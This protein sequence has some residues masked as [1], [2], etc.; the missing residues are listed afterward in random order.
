[1]VPLTRILYVDDEIDIQTIVRIALENIGGFN[2]KICS[3]GSEALKIAPEF[4]PDLILLDVMM[5]DMDGIATLKALRK[6]PKTADIP[7]IFMTA[8]AQLHEIEQYKELGV[9]HIIT[10]PFD[11]LVLPMNINDI[12]KEFYIPNE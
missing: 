10:K 1:M 9:L 11:P 5:P 12:W 4:N 6:I 2:V 7:V 3:S 8:K